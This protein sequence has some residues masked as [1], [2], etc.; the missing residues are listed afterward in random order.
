[1]F[2]YAFWKIGWEVEVDWKEQNKKVVKIMYIIYDLN[3]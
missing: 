1:M 2:E 3:Q